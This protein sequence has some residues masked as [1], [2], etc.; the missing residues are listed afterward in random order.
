MKLIKLIS[1]II[2]STIVSISA[3]ELPQEIISQQQ[4]LQAV[5]KRDHTAAQNFLLLGLDPNFT[6]EQ[7]GRDPFY[8]SRYTDHHYSTPLKIAIK[9]QDD[10]MVRLLLYHKANPNYGREHAD[11]IKWIFSIRPEFDTPAITTIRNFLLNHPLTDFN[12]SY[13]KHDF[14]KRPLLHTV[15]LFRLDLLPFVLTHQNIDINAKDGA[16]QTSIMAVVQRKN[17]NQ[18]SKILLIFLK[19]PELK[20]NEVSDAGK[21]ALDYAKSQVIKN[22]LIKNGAKTGQELNYEKVELGYEPSEPRS[23]K[24]VVR[25]SPFKPATYR[26]LGLAPDADPYQILGISPRA[27]RLEIN[28]AFVKQSKKWLPENNPYKPEAK[29][30]FSLLNWAY[31]QLVHQ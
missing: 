13:D 9:N 2:L 24:I 28:D 1:V 16:G 3:M 5:K 30:V 27:S 8:S 20:I 11:F 21:T 23:T 14:H 6:F 31:D 25:P 18:A 7:W 22:L 15:S 12:T 19:N 10:N 26:A 17:T 4:F 29:E